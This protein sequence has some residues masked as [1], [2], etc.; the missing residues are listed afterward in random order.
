MAQQ[1][2]FVESGFDRVQDTLKSL[3]SDVDKFQS[4][5]E[6]QR[7]RLERET[8][9]RVTKFRKEISETPWAKRAEKFS[10]DASREIESRVE[11]VLGALSIASNADLKKVN[12]KLNQINRR[13]KA[14]EVQDSTKTP[15]GVTS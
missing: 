7:K 14:L 2:S 13:L 15:P 9:K 6:T 3:G 5:V 12:R 8:R 10:K 1:A 4:R 11:D